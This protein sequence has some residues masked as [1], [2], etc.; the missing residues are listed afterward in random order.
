MVPTST[1]R[2]ENSRCIS[3]P[4]RYTVLLRKSLPLYLGPKVLIYVSLPLLAAGYSLPEGIIIHPRFMAIG[5]DSP[6]VGVG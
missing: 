1:F 6:A 2:K 4:L 3:Q 5:G